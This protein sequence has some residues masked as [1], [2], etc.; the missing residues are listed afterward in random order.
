MKG[1]NSLARTFLIQ[2]RHGL[3]ILVLSLAGCANN[4]PHD[5]NTQAASKVEAGLAAS[6]KP[7][8]AEKPRSTDEKTDTATIDEF[9]IF[10]NPGDTEVDI[11]GQVKL[12]RH[13]DYLKM[14]PK[15]KLT[16][17]GHTGDSGSRSFNLAI[18]EQRILSVR[19]L[20]NSYGVSPRLFRPHSVIKDRIPANCK[21]IDCSK[22]AHR[23]ELVLLP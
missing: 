12:R 2:F 20:L 18:A 15:K 7:N 6:S 11:A 10:F 4:Q 5:N 9:N 23:V 19:K 13:A 1:S 21:S 17:V 16:L 3:L 14:N 8:A 22:M